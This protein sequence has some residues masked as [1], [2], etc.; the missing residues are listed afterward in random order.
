MISENKFIQLETVIHGCGG[1]K[2]GVIF[3][4]IYICRVCKFKMVNMS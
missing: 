4:S 2:G 3:F 1:W